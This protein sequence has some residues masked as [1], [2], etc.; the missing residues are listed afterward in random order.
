M[1]C[2]YQY[3]SN[4]GLSSLWPSYRTDSDVTSVN[5]CLISL[6]TDT[7]TVWLSLSLGPV[8]VSANFIPFSM[9]Y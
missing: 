4:L 1:S 9:L 8:T 7:Y 5:G 6:E 2:S 3:Y